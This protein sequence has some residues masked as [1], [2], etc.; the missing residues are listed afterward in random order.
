[1]L[2]RTVSLNRTMSWVTS[3]IWDRS[4]ARVTSRMSMPSISDPARGR[5]VEAGQQVDDGRLA[6]AAEA[7]QGH[8]L[9]RLDLEADVV[10]DRPVGLVGEA[11]GLEADPALDGRQGI[12][13]GPVL[14]LARDAQDLLDPVQA[15]DG[16]DDHVLG[17]GQPLDGREQREDGHGEGAEIAGAD[18][19]L[20]EMRLGCRRTG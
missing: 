6:G 17:P 1:M 12:G 2:A 11:D 7:D 20:A 10:Q 8:R 3:P 5:L 13:A 16:L 15:G 18:A 4:E 9:A 19:A 14:D